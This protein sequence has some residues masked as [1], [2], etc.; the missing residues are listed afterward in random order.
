[1]RATSITGSSRL[2][3]A[4]KY[5]R[6]NYEGFEVEAERRQSVPHNLACSARRSTVLQSDTALAH[7]SPCAW[8]RGRRCAL[9]TALATD[10]SLTRASRS[11]TTSVYGYPRPL[12]RD[13]ARAG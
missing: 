12:P 4:Q 6:F 2:W 5:Q 7:G 13:G 9:R 8:T 1:M 3:V 11:A 10:T